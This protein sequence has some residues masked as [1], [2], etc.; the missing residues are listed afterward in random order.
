MLYT[1][2][3]NVRMLPQTQITKLLWRDYSF[4]LVL[5]RVV[6]LLHYDSFIHSLD[7]AWWERWR[8]RNAGF[9]TFERA[10]EV[11][12]GSFPLLDLFRLAFRFVLAPAWMVPGP[13]SLSAPRRRSFDSDGCH[14]P[15]VLPPGDDTEGF[16]KDSIAFEITIPR[17]WFCRQ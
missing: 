11:L 13:S 7:L 3:L 10:Y 14:P 4:E 1:D 8:L 5:T 12:C 2:C 16:F 6:L 15:V 17:S 9:S